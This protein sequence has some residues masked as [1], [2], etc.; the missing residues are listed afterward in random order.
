MMPEYGC[1][2]WNLLYDPFDDVTR[3]NIVSEVQKVIDGDPRV[4]ANSIAVTSFD[5][6]IR[7]Q[8]DLYYVPF[9]VVDT[10]SLDFDR[11]T[12]ESY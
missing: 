5:Q 10:F 2:V 1:A 8:M 3:E 12:A 9:R 11:R 4:Q 6:G 7:V